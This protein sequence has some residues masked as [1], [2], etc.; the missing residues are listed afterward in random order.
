MLEYDNTPMNGKKGI[1]FIDFSPEIYYLL[2][3]ILIRWTRQ[4][5][6]ATNRFLFVNSWNE[7]NEGNYLEPDEKYGYSSI[8][9]L[10]KALFNITFNENK[11]NISNLI[12][13][14]KIAIQAHIFFVDLLKEII[15]KTNNI[16]AKFDLF[17]TTN[18]LNKSKIINNSLKAYS[19][20]NKYEIK[21]V[22]HLNASYN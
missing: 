14:S 2:N 4:F 17:I 10:S 3:R 7:W 11:Y 19:K 16:P 1:V 13:S 8:N 5:Y 12:L 22:E 18:S 6:N 21:I 9:A 20:A 15:N